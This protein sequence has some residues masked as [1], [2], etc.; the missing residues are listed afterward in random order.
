VS[1]RFPLNQVRNI[2]IIAHI[3]AGKTTVTE[4][5]LYYTGR[6]Y[7]IGEVHDGTAVMDWMEQERE[8]GITIT[9][10]ATTCYWEE[11]RI[12]IIDTPGHV[13]FTAE[14][15]RSLR[16]LDG[17]VVVFDAVAGVEAQSEVVWRQADRYHVPRICFIN[18][19]DRIGADFNRALSMI[20][21]RLKATPLTVQLPLGSEASFEGI[22]D[23]IENKMW[24]FSADLDAP[25]REV[26]VPESEQARSREA[27]QTLIEKLA[28]ADDEVMVAYLEGRDIAPAELKAA[29]RRVTLANKGVP[30][31]CG[32]ALKNKGVQRLLDAIIDYLPSPVDVPPVKAVDTRTGSEVIRPPEDNAPLI[33]LAFKV[34]TDPF[35]GRLVYLRLYSGNV[36]AGAQVFNA[37][38]SKR[39]RIGR[40]LLM[41]A[42]H[43]EE[44]EEA[45]T[46]AI[47]A[48]LGLKDT[49]T[50]DTLCT[51][52]QPVLLESIH[53]P[54]PVVAVAIEPKSR[55]DQDK[56]GEALNKLAE[57]DPTFKVAYNQ[58]TGQTVISG[59]G[60]LHL[61]VLVGRLFSEF[62]VGARV[63]RPWVAYKETITVPV[64]VEGRFVKQSGGRGQFGHVWLELEPLE[65]GGGFQFVDKVKDGSIKRQY[66]PAVE[67]GVREAAETGVIAGYP[68]VDIKA[69]LYDG[70][71]HDV[72]SSDLAFKMAG[73]IALKSG[74][75][76]SRPVLLEPVMK[77][78]VVTPTP[79]LGDIIG[80]LSS[81]RGQ[82][83]S[84]ETE[85]EMSIV[86]SS[87]PLAEMFGYAT[88]IRSL[89]QGR[90]THSMGFYRYQE[91]PADLAEKIKATGER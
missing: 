13:D 29:L 46:G 8:R 1:G 20:E 12:N 76:K 56:I 79:F 10:A 80:D 15:E 89:T 63:G 39:E 60:E 18:K 72:D 26:P 68:V 14:V 49:F 55:I 34:V 31:L 40:L 67:A 19:M 58:E 59:M 78:E 71:Y 22:I 42:N 32:S 2:A 64:R 87:V 50:G 48:T 57:E 91:V 5:V 3:D 90:A 23:L 61:E 53:F 66:I 38:R 69:T 35:V 84:I 81:K 33:A 4:R 47:V 30:I 74:V 52:N 6:T 44:I 86:R 36:K 70:S 17:G 45:D 7:K 65:R 41:H 24:H 77:L 85:N 27:R 21:Q 9:A 43:R 16:V 11:C 83:G 28:E 51:Q 75:R 73:S 88:D 25:P 82:I 37:T 54:E 62:K